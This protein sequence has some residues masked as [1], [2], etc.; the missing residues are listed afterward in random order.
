MSKQLNYLKSTF[1]YFDLNCGL[2]FYYSDDGYIGQD[3]KGRDV[4]LFDN[5]IHTGEKLQHRTNDLKA[6]G[7]RSIYAFAIHGLTSAPEL[8]K[9][10]NQ[11]PVKELILTNTIQQCRDVIPLL[12]RQ[13]N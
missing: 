13:A 5:I 10:V 8:L 11:L 7:A 12:F 4:I 1:Q 2:G 6:K 3:I 9:M